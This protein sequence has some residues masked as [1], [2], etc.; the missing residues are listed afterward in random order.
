LLRS[1]RILIEVGDGGIYGGIG[2]SIWVVT[3]VVFPSNCGDKGI[4]HIPPDAVPVKCQPST[5]IQKSY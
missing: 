1:A 5:N 3:P 2:Q 4:L